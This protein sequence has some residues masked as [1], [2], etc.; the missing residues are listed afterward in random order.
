MYTPEAALV[1][2]P[3]V[4]PQDDISFIPGQIPRR[5][6]QRAP[7]TDYTETI[8]PA[9]HRNTKYNPT[10]PQVHRYNNRTHCLQQKYL[11]ENHVA[12]INTP[13]A[14]PIKT[15]PLVRPDG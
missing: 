14:A 9:E 7:H 3:R 15:A 2:P 8:L 4:D 12:T 6:P 10:V 13:A 1:S 11:M 5:S